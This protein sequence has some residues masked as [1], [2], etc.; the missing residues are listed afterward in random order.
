M[1]TSY[2]VD[3]SIEVSEDLRSDDSTL[4]STV[5]TRTASMFRP[6]QTVSAQLLV[7]IGILISSIGIAA[8]AVVLAVLVRARREFGSSVHTL[9]SNQSQ[10]DL[11]PILRRVHE[12][13]NPPP[14]LKQSP[15]SPRWISLLA[16]SPWSAISRC[17]RTATADN[18]IHFQK[19][20]RISSVFFI[21][22]SLLDRYCT[23]LTRSRLRC[24]SQIVQEHLWKST[25]T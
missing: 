12:S 11:G 22:S 6:Q 19:V 5:V 21:F 25:S 14:Q 10:N 2:T 17:S 15:T 23:T 1:T 24:W 20:A 8:N 7:P 3:Y 18:Y 13:L 9:I 4:N 16:S